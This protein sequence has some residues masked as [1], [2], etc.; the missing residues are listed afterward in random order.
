MG[1]MKDH[2][3]YE[4][5]DKEAPSQIKDRNGEVCLA[6]CKVCCGAECSLPTNC[7]GRK[8]SLKESELICNGE[9]DF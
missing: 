9:L 1:K 5:F 2:V 8:R 3:L 7:P 4:G 6:L